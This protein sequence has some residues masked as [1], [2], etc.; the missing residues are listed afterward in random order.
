M[1][2]VDA[3]VIVVALGDDGDA[4]RLVRQ[5]LRGERLSAPEVIDLEVLSAW[6]RLVAAGALTDDRAL[7]SVGDLMDLRV[8][9]VSHRFLME[10]CWELR[11]NLTAYDAAYVALAER[12]DTTL[13]TVDGPLARAP[14]PRCTIELLT[15]ELG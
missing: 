13:V 1:I 11:S 8:R 5:R 9:R 10:R 15:A 2:V 7:Q 12:L 6:R 3:S 4:G 14:G